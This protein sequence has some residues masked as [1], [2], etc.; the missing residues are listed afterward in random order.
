MVKNRQKIVKFSE[1]TDF[2]ISISSQVSKYPDSIFNIQTLALIGQHENTTSVFSLKVRFHFYTFLLLLQN[3]TDIIPS[4]HVLYY[5][6]WRRTIIP[7]P[8]VLYY[9]YWRRTIIPHD[10]DIA[11]PTTPPPFSSHR[12][13]WHHDRMP[14]MP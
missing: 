10:S 9:R 1:K 6:Y 4:P 2:L 13:V 12:P 7:S 5:R 11:C 8:H 3:I 14:R